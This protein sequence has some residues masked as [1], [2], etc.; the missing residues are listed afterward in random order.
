MR[1]IL[2]I[3]ALILA[4]AVNIN[5]QNAG[6]SVIVIPSVYIVP[7]NTPDSTITIPSVF[8]QPTDT[9]KIVNKDVVVSDPTENIPLTRDSALML[10]KVYAGILNTTAFSIK[11]AR[12][13]NCFSFRVGAKFHWSIG[14]LLSIN[15]FATLDYT[16]GNATP[17]NS[18]SIRLHNRSNIFG[19]EMGYMATPASE[20]RPLPP[21][22]PGQFE[23]YTEGSAPGLAFGIKAGV[24]LS[25]LSSISAG[26]FIRDKALEYH[27]RFAS[28][29]FDISGYANPTNK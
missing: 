15:S 29:H 19:V 18:I 16:D 9:I 8:I 24:M 1:K 23:T 4:F 14:Q 7:P 5:A 28:K 2:V 21:S 20:S 13:A 11:E 27:L 10:D 6:D 12:V 3:F 26:A 17:I 25:K 22:G